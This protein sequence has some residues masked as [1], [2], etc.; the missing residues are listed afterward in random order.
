MKLVTF[1]GEDEE[2]RI[3]ALADGDKEIID[4]QAGALAKENAESPYFASMLAF[5]EGGPQ[6]REKGQE[7]VE[8]VRSKSPPDVRIPPG[9]VRLLA[10]LPHPQSIR[11]CLTF[12]QHIINVIRVAGL[13]K[14]APLDEWIER[15]FGRKRSLAYM[16]CKSFY[17]RPLYYKSNCFSVVGTDAEVRMPPFTQRF[18]YELEWGA[19][20]GKKGVDI[21][22]EK[23]RSYIGGYTVFNDFSARDIQLKEQA[24]RLGPTKGKDF[25][26]GNAM[27]PCLVTP[28][29]IGDPYDLAMT[30]RVN[31]EEWS[32]G[33][34]TADMGWSF[35]DLIW[36]I[37]QSETLYPGEF[38][39][40]GTCSGAECMGCG[41]EMGKFLKVGDVVELEVEGIGVLRNKI[42][43]S[44]A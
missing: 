22:R 5:L 13:K 6:A 28:D 38:L 34:T 41:M 2:Q 9:S 32:R 33:G 20:I 40:S 27:G 36:Y 43:D 23:A 3:A 16:A 44:Y 30:A 37:S 21:P 39:G 24:G 35:E 19:Y 11:D 8:Y 26:T 25:D 42:V 15:T 10:P 31:G 1:L 17:E 14:L 18:D 7:I 12:E 4:L 29:E